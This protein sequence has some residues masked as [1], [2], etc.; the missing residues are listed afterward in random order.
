MIQAYVPRLKSV[1]LA[2]ALMLAS[3]A[4]AAPV[5]YGKI[6]LDATYSLGGGSPVNGMTDPNGFISEYTNG[7]AVTGADLYLDNRVGANG[8]FFHT[9]GNAD[10]F[11]S[12]YFGARATGWGSFTAMTSTRYQDTFVNTSG[13]DQSYSF[14]FNVDWGGVDIYGSSGSALA[15][16]LLRVT[17]NGNVVAQDKTTVN[18][19]AAGNQTCTEADVGVLS[20]YIGCAQKTSSSRAYTVDLGSFANNELITLQYDI[21]ST[22]S[23]DFGSTATCYTYGAEAGGGD[24]GYGGDGYGGTIGDAEVNV[25]R[26]LEEVVDITE[27]EGFP[28]FCTYETGQVTTQSGDPFNFPPFNTAFKVTANNVPEPASLALLGLGAAGLAAARRRQRQK[29]S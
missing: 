18:Q 5:T 21:I 6:T 23:G 14:S 4:M 22:I 29:K 16:L 24:N 25:N 2:V 10:P 26:V 27:R 28:E 20:D 17:V 12:T 9:Y 7:G 13:T 15:E 3:T 8:V 1:P 19:D 11:G